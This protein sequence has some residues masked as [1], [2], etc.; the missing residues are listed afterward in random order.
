LTRLMGGDVT[1]SSVVGHGAC[2]TLQIPAS[3]ADARLVA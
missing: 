2:F 1:M 3:P